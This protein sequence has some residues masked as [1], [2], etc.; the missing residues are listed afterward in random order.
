MTVG[1]W[2]QAAPKPPTKAPAKPRRKLRPLNG[3]QV[4]FVAEY[5]K[6]RNATQAARRAG[7][8]RKTAHAIGPRLLDNVGI[9]EALAAADRRVL[10][11]A[12]V[13]RERVLREIALVGFANPQ[14]A[15]DD[16]NR[17]LPIRQMPETVA[18]A[19]TFHKTPEGEVRFNAKLPALKALGDHLGL[20][21]TPPQPVLQVEGKVTVE[22]L[23]AIWALG[24]DLEAIETKALP[25]SA[26][27][28]RIGGITVEE[29]RAGKE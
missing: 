14:D 29:I 3:R 21:P 12:E 5:L 10:A 13:S 6:D 18:R 17:L 19:L 20:F 4:L 7:Y 28:E 26:P 9:Q 11:R 23:R 1:A 25:A 27:E 24:D 8:S 15:F 22:Q 16:E 2:L